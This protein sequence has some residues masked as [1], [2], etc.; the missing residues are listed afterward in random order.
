MSDEERLQ[1][2]KNKKIKF[3]SPTKADDVNID[4][5]ITKCT[6]SHNNSVMDERSENLS[7]LEVTIKNASETDCYEMIEVCESEECLPITSEHSEQSEKSFCIS[8]KQSNTAEETLCSVIDR[9]IEGTASPYD[10]SVEWPD[11]YMVRM[12]FKYYCL[13]FI[14]QIFLQ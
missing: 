3:C 6:L 10:S 1:P 12:Y 14:K 11:M 4:D 9:I 8:F 13:Q 5:L 7:E 2:P